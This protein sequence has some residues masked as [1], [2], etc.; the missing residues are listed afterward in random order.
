M[1]KSRTC[2]NHRDCERCGKPV[3]QDSDYLRA[4]L[5]GACVFFHW[6]CFIALM[7][8][9]DQRNASSIRTRGAMSPC[10]AESDRIQPLSIGTAQPA[11]QR[12]QGRINRPSRNEG[13]P[14]MTWSKVL[15]TTGLLLLSAAG[16]ALAATSGL[17]VDPTITTF[18][19]VR[20]VGA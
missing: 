19:N 6:S 12:L 4:Q 9:S 14:F 20:R 3:R 18:T 8:D 1:A 13:E 15:I 7:R 10:G 11:D 5:R 17:P 16:A 2:P